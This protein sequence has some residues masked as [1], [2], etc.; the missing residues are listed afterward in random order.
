MKELNNKK[1]LL[2]DDEKD[3]LSMTEA[4]LQ[5]AGFFHIFTA[6]NC[7]EAMAITRTHTIALCILDVMLPDGDG[8]TLFRKI[9]TI[10]EAPVIFL[11]AKGEAEDKIR[12]LELGADDYMVKPFLMKELVLRVTA[13]LRRTYQLEP[14][15]EGVQL[16]G[17]YI[18]F[19]TGIVQSG[20]REIRLTAKEFILLKKLY[21]NKNRIVTSDA[22]CMAAWG[23]GY[24]GYENTL[25]VHIRRLREKIEEIPSAPQHLLTVKG[26]GY[27]LVVTEHE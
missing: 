21:E 13:L 3:L 12:G 6:K 27:K 8:F 4:A 25:M 10:S 5:A 1:I 15:E 23:D 17:H 7:E 20:Q 16:G 18:S 14:K 24:Y 22:L 2:V 19:A 26:L 9:R 11:T